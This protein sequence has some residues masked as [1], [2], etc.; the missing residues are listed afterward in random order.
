MFVVQ[1]RDAK[2]LIPIVQRNIKTGSD[3]HSDEWRAY[4]RLNEMGYN[5]FKVNHKENILNPLTGK[6]T[7]LVECLWGVNKRQLPNRIRS[8]SVDILQLYHA[9][10]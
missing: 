3:I 4:K 1:R 8:K 2:T 10:Q 9:Q 5:P 6:H 7:Q